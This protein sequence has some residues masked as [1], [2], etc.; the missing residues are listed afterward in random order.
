MIDWISADAPMTKL[1]Y[2]AV[3]TANDRGYREL[4][5]SV[6]AP[7]GRFK[8]VVNV[9]TRRVRFDISP[10]KYLVGHN[11]F[12]TNDL[13]RI[14]RSILKLIYKRF[15]LTFSERDAAFYAERGMQLSR[16][17]VNGCFLVGSQ[18]K[19]VETMGLLRKHFLDHGHSIVVHE[20]PDGIETLYLGK[21]SSNSTLKFYNK[22][23][24]MLVTGNSSNLPYYTELLSLA[25][26][27]VRFEVTKRAPALKA[28]GLDSS[29]EWTV[30]T[31]R[32]ILERALHDVGLSSKLLAE[33]PDDDVGD[34][35]AATRAKYS[36]WMAGI[37][38]REHFPGYTFG[39][40]R[41]IFLGKGIDIA[42]PRDRAKE[43]VLLSERLSVAKLKT[44]WPKR[45]VPLGAVYR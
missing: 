11:L 34:L 35:T 28:S 44:G 3:V 29:K 2:E 31:T 7:Y 13:M 32:E 23:R 20:G 16:V 37:D 6:K 36:L 26:K 24:E 5:A 9:E 42:R 10:I 41:K 30:G 45:F 39:R 43:A 14:L 17:D 8:I 21:N 1:F 18:V 38:L 12:G 25:E 4:W 33:L 27:L 40:D 19:V 15:G 22:Y